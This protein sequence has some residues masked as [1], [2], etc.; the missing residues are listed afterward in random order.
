MQTEFLVV[1]MKRVRLDVDEEWFFSYLDH[2]FQSVATE[3]FFPD[4]PILSYR[5]NG[6]KIPFMTRC[7]CSCVNVCVIT[8]KDEC[9]TSDNQQSLS[10][11][12]V[13][14][15]SSSTMESIIIIIKIS[16][17]SFSS[18]LFSNFPSL[19]MYVHLQVLLHFHQGA[20]KQKMASIFSAFRADPTTIKPTLSAEGYS[21]TQVKEKTSRL[22]ISY[23][24]EAQ[25]GS[26]FRCPPNIN[27][28]APSSHWFHVIPSTWWWFFLILLSS[29]HS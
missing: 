5:K 22:Q 3:N 8:T 15:W 9:N 12:L 13:I 18:S 7:L 21:Y 26:P 20:S 27:W 19:N 25:P 2:I 16:Y 11:W 10:G 6:Q 28:G 23:V 1:A 14:H 29:Y 17:P 4:P 24:L